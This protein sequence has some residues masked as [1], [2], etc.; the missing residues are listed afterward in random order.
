M[1][2]LAALGGGVSVQPP[3]PLGLSELPVRARYRAMWGR[4]L[5]G[6]RTGAHL[7]A[8]RRIRRWRAALLFQP[9]PGIRGVR[10]DRRRPRNAAGFCRVA[11]RAMARAAAP[12]RN[13][14]RAI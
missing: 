11:P 9:H 6:A 3:A 1:A 12:R 5:A 13:P 7:A 2:L 14:R 8:R 4:T 10:A